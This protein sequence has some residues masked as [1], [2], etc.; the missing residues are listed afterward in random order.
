MVSWFRNCKPEL[1][2]SYLCKGFRI[3]LLDLYKKIFE[4]ID[5]FKNLYIN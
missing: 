5:R 3:R 4:L 2:S 1:I